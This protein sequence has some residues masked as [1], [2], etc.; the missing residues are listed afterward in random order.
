MVENLL[1][2]R[3]AVSLDEM[4]FLVT[5]LTPDDKAQ[6]LEY[7]LGGSDSQAV[8]DSVDFSQ[9]FYAMSAWMVFKEN[10]TKTDERERVK[11]FQF[12]LNR[13]R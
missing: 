7:L 10:Q 12:P 8:L 4:K 3:G 13:Y 11:V 1:G 6:L 2:C 5:Q 9:L